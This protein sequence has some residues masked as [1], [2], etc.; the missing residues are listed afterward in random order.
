MLQGH[1]VTLGRSPTNDVVLDHDGTISSLHA[2]LESYAGGWTLRDLG[3]RNGTY[4]DG[5]QLVTEQALRGGT[6]VRL[7]GTRI[8]FRSRT[9]PP[10]ERTESG[11]VAPTLTP[12]ERDVVR[13]LCRPLFGSEMFRQPATVKDIAAALVVSDGAVKQHLG[14]LYDKFGIDP[15]QRSRLTLANEALRR[16]AVTPA[17]LIRGD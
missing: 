6:E 11:I 14:N 5:T 10:S 7:G 4:V 17:E 3:S 12:R 1:R 9:T 2:V 13:A 16:G 8:V 15:R